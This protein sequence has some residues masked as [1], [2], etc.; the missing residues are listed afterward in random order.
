MDRERSQP[1]S[2]R[3]IVDEAAAWFVEI[4]EGAADAATRRQFDAWLRASPEHVRA[5]LEMLPIWEDGAHLERGANGDPQALLAWAEAQSKVVSLSG[6]DGPVSAGGAVRAGSSPRFFQSPAIFRGVRLAA[7]IAVLCVAAAW[8]AWL[9]GGRG[10]GYQTGVGEQ[11]SIALA[12]GSSVELNSRSRIRV[13][14]T[15][16][17]RGIDL[18]EGQALF[19]VVQDPARPFLVRSGGTRVRAVG[20]RF[21]VYRK[22]AGTLVTVLE[23]R[24]AVLPEG[25]IGETEPMDGGGGDVRSSNMLATHSAAY[26][27]AG[28]QA[29]VT[30]AATSRPQRADVTAATAWTQQRLVFS[31]T[32]LTE[33]AEEFNRYNERQ[34]LIEDRELASFN[35]SGTFSSRDPAALLRFLRIQPGIEVEET[36]D[37]IL[38]SVKEGRGEGFD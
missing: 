14:F 15:A 8:G 21:D 17:Q 19:E 13:R 11:L 3:Q 32:P 22:A 4:N 23:G 10:S 12:D 37:G 7:S 2:N 9:L 34:L 6:P 25:Y 27:S 30:P 38:L 20:T 31:R 28:E 29:I 24:V 36:S 5:Y 1:A 33:V 26:L 16:Q 18:L 35:V